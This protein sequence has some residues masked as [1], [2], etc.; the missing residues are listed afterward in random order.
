MRLLA[1]QDI[2][3]RI[4]LIEPIITVL[5][6]DIL[7]AN[8]DRYSYT[9]EALIDITISYQ[10]ANGPVVIRR[11]TLAATSIS[12]E[13]GLRCRLT[14]SAAFLAALMDNPSQHVQDMPMA[15]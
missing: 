10:T 2:A 13:P 4:G 9:V 5:Q 14:R 8:R 7:W 12:R 6:A 11:K 15:A 3:D 1:S